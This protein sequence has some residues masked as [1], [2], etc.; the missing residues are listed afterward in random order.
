VARRTLTPLSALAIGALA[1][2]AGTAAMDT[3]IYKRYT[4]GGGDQGF[5]EWET[6]AGTE[7]Y[8]G[9]PAPAQ[10]GKRLVEGYLQTE[11]PPASARSMTNAMHWMTGV[12]WGVNHAVVVGSMSRRRS[13][14]GLLTGMAAWTASYA[15]L[16]PAGLYEPIWSYPADV[17]IKDASAHAVYGSVTGT[18][19]RLLAGARAK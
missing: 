19:F 1:G 8:D 17:L 12:A 2:I 9:A 4:A 15:T 16:A 7:S 18:V 11:L 3:L 5:L 13:A 6:A 10:V 14:Y